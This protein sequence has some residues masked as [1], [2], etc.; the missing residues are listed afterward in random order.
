MA[1]GNNTNIDSDTELKLLAIETAKL[2]KELRLLGIE[3]KKS[4]R[5]AR[6]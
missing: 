3:A 6:V 1:N 4:R 2:D 5:I